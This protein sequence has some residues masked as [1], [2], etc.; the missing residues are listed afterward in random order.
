MGELEASA[1]RLR[2]AVAGECWKQ[3]LGMLPEY[4]RLLEEALRAAP[5]GTP[6]TARVAREARE[7]MDFTRRMVRVCRA[8]A[9]DRLA[10]LECAGRYRPERPPRRRWEIEG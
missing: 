7:L 10:G 3:A 4:G 6:E 8:H 2:A 5:A 9:A 1:L